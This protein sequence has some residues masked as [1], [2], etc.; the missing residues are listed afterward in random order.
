MKNR[1]L[2]LPLTIA[3][4]ASCQISSVVAKTVEV[5]IRGTISDSMCK[6]GHEGMIK[7]GGYGKTEAACV[8][9]CFAQGYKPVLVDKKSGV[10]YV[11][12]NPKI[13]KK[14]TGKTVIVTGNVDDKSKVVQIHHLREE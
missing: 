4:V 5:T 12:S 8:Q 9:K 1:L 3:I 10:I 11:V 13:A 7:M 2:T 14:F 6:G